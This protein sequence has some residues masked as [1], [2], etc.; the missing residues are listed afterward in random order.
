VY[1]VVQNTLGQFRGQQ[2]LGAFE[3][4]LEMHK[5]ITSRTF[6]ISSTILIKDF[7]LSKVMFLRGLLLF[8]H[9]I[10][11]YKNNENIPTLSIINQI[12]RR[13][14]FRYEMHT[15]VHIYLLK[16]IWEK[17]T[18]SKRWTSFYVL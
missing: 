15:Y 8:Y 14:T 12:R 11:Y 9:I 13:N 10:I 5:K 1:L 16:F 17:G 18:M 2:R 4:P 7:V 6:R 3:K